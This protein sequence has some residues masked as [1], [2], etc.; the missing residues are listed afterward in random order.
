MIWKGKRDYAAALE[1]KQTHNLKSEKL[2]AT[3]LFT[4]RRVCCHEEEE[5][6]EALDK[7]LVSWILA[8]MDEPDTSIKNKLKFFSLKITESLLESQ[9]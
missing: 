3:A 1:H 5:E 2:T 6:E 9:F 8:L 7:T 4:R